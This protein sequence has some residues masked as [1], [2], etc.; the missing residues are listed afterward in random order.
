MANPNFFYTYLNNAAQAG[1]VMK[2]AEI[3]DP[4]EKLAIGDCN[5]RFS[6]VGLAEQLQFSLG[7]NDN[8]G[9]LSIYPMDYL[10]PPG[11]MFAGSPDAN[12]D[13]IL[14]AGE[15]GFRYRHGQTSSSDTGWGNAVFFDG[16]VESISINNNITGAPPHRPT[17][18]G[19]KGLRILNIINPIEPPSVIMVY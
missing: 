7:Q 6:N 16:H 12:S 13:T 4:T 2:V 17:S 15:V 5:Q 10:I 1:G 14:D 19:T 3:S 11:G 8:P 9:A 18:L